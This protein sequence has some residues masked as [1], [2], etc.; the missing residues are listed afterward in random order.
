[1]KQTKDSTVEQL[2]HLF[3]K[4]TGIARSSQ[5]HASKLPDKGRKIDGCIY[6]VGGRDA[7]DL[8]S[9]ANKH[10]NEATY[11]LRRGEKASEASRPKV[12]YT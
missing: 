7:D 2:E 6:G 10:M 12:C 4:F 11:T 1:M 8:M 5:A 9:M 3:S